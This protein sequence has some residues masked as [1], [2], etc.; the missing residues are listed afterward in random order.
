MN[1]DEQPKGALVENVELGKKLNGT[2]FQIH[3]FGARAIAKTGSQALD[4]FDQMYFG[5]G[6]VK[7]NEI[8]PPP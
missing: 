2:V 3:D 8:I 1:S 6:D 4:P 5:M 7:G